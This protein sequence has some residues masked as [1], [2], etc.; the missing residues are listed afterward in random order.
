MLLF[1]PKKHLGRRL[2]ITLF[3]IF[4]LL[5]NPVMLNDLK[6]AVTSKSDALAYRDSLLPPI[7]TVI[8][9]SSSSDD[10]V[11]AVFCKDT[12]DFQTVKYLSRPHRVDYFDGQAF[13]SSDVFLDKKTV[14]NETAMK[15]LVTRYQYLISYCDEASTQQ[16]IIDI[17]SNQPPLNY[18]DAYRITIDDDSV[19]LDLL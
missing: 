19:K 6:P 18:G 9:H 12:I 4:G 10:A 15:Q 2:A 13:S 14:D 5:I 7:N 3:I 16:P 1:Q 8:S 17:L 11:L